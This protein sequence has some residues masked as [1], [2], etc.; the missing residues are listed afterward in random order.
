M[1]KL[2]L[3]TSVI[4]ALLSAPTMAAEPATASVKAV[5]FDMVVTHNG[6]VTSHKEGFA[7]S[8]HDCDL[9]YTSELAQAEVKFKVDE[10]NGVKFNYGFILE[11]QLGNEMDRIVREY[12]ADM[13]QI[14][15]MN[16]GGEQSHPVT[17]KTKL[18]HLRDSGFVNSFTASNQG[19]V[20]NVTKQVLNAEGMIDTFSIAVTY[21]VTQL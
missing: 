4:T 10:Q 1:N 14:Y 12:D 13:S 21:K 19:N 9:R 15:G 8:G 7:T 5:S 20:I 6:E 11:N 18:I 3:C 16:Y 17:K 2:L